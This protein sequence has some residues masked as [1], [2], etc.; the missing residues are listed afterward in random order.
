MPS[1]PDTQPLDVAPAPEAMIESKP[2]ETQAEKPPEAAKLEPPPEPPVSSEVATAV[3][4]PP[5]EQ[6]PLTHKE[7]PKKDEPRPV[8]A[9]KQPPAP[10]T[11]PPAPAKHRAA[12]PA[13]PRA[14]STAANAR[15]I[16]PSWRDRLVAH[17]Q[18]HKRYPSS[19]Q[20]RREEGVVLLGFSMDRSGRV[21]ARRIARSS[22]HSDLDAEAMSM[23]QRA[24]PLPAFPATM[25]QARLDL[26]VP[27]RFSLR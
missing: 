20:S 21:I 15:A 10:L 7:E 16:D 25:S 18:R 26:T 3:L 4:P 17:L 24:Q 19:A 2:P 8:E 6:K 23:I 9:Q 5:P 14:G 1:A 13:T 22:G 11:A 27:I 12:I